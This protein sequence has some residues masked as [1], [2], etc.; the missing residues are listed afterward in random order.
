MAEE[1]GLLAGNWRRGMRDAADRRLDARTPLGLLSPCM[2]RGVH[3]KESPLQPQDLQGGAS[4]SEVARMA[5]EHAKHHGF[6]L[7]PS[8]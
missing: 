5:I 4:I 3:A 6:Q 1:L 7:W 8:W 2:V